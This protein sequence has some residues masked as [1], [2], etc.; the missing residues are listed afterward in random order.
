M[1]L[2]MISRTQWKDIRDRI[3]KGGIQELKNFTETMCQSVYQEGFE[4]GYRQGVDEGVDTTKASILEV[5]DR[6]L[7]KEFGFGRKR[8]AQFHECFIEELKDKAFELEQIEIEE[9]V[10]Q[11]VVTE[12]DSQRYMVLT[13]MATFI[14]KIRQ[15][16]NSLMFKNKA[17]YLDKIYDH[18]VLLLQQ[19]QKEIGENA[20]EEIMKQLEAMSLFVAPNDFVKNDK[21]S[22]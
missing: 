4:K 10:Q 22:N 21:V 20:N 11:T 2:Q 12:D 18:T 5:V 16:E 7:K 3:K 8:T 1:N 9:P 13:C 17:P 19:I 15:D 14:E 6:T